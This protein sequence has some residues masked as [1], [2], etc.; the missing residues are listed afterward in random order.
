MGCY[1]ERLQTSGVNNPKT[2]NIK[3]VQF[4]RY[5]FYMSMCVA[6]IPHLY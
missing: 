2:I 1:K 3:N 6:Q 4:S 5:C